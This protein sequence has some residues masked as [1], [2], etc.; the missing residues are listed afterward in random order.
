MKESKPTYEELEYRVKL[1]ENEAK[2]RVQAQK[3]LKEREEMLR[4][5]EEKYRLIFENVFDVIFSF[6][7]EFKL[8][9]VSPSIERILG[10]KPEE[11]IGRPFPDLNI[12]TSESLEAAIPNAIRALAGESIALT[13]YEFIARDG[14]RKVVELTSNPLFR[15]G[16]VV[17]VIC[18]ARDITNKTLAK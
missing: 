17:A 4:T 7:P 6:D 1:L 12:L 2:W 14:T 3:V 10:Y 11:V 18:V 16:K 8:L 13:V 15:N 9:N 5:S